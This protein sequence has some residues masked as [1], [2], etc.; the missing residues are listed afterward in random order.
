MSWNGTLLNDTEAQNGISDSS[1]LTFPVGCVYQIYFR[2]LPDG[3]WIPYEWFS[4]VLND[5][6]LST[7][8]VK[9]GPMTINNPSAG[10]IAGLYNQGELSVEWLNLALENF[11]TVASNYMRT[12][13]PRDTGDGYGMSAHDD[14]AIPQNT[15]FM[16]PPDALAPSIVPL[17]PVL[18]SPQDW[19]QPING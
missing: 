5:T 16:P 11:T 9:D 10:I 4:N 7:T 3:Q 15:S 19:N 1:N 6:T 13:D 18:S 17:N 2:P 14:I 12:L 8:S